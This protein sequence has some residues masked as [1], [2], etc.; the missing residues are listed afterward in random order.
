MEPQLLCLTAMTMLAHQG[1]WLELPVLSS[2]QLSIVD[3]MQERKACFVNFLLGNLA[4][5][6]YIWCTYK[7][8]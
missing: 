4:L 5:Y 3:S 7:A 6:I 8:I 2:V 1:L